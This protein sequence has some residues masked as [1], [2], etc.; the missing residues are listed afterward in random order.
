MLHDWK[1]SLMSEVG[2]S[3]MISCYEEGASFV[4]KIDLHQSNIVL[5]EIL[6]I[7]AC[8]LHVKS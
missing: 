8:I 2:R 7:T 1:I 5:A 6:L 3:V 4:L